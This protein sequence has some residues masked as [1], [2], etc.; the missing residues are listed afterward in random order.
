MKGSQFV[1]F[2]DFQ[3]RLERPRRQVIVAVGFE[4]SSVCDDLQDNG[5]LEPAR[6]FPE[7]DEDEPS[8]YYLC[9][10]YPEVS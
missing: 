4:V 9:S 3:A 7:I 6:R 10:E 2:P 1:P 5:F 8:R